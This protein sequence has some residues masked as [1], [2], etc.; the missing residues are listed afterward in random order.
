MLEALAAAAPALGALGGGGRTST[1]ISNTQNV[2]TNPVILN[3]FGS[4]PFGNLSPTGGAYAAPSTASS[5]A[6]NDGQGGLPSYLPSGVSQQRSTPLYGDQS[7]LGYPAGTQ[8]ISG[9]GADNSMMPLLLA[10]GA[11]LLF[12]GMDQERRDVPSFQKSSEEVRRP[13]RR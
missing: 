9:S 5:S 13:A 7:V 4:G 6:G 3:N 11:L 2:A 10:G 1:S 12:L 8:P